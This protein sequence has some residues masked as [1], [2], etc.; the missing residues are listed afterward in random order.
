MS[1][2]TPNPNGIYPVVELNF[3]GVFL[4]NPF[5]YEPGMKFTFDD[6]DFS[7]MTY[8]ECITFLERFMQESIKKLYYYKP[9][10]PLLSGIAAIV[11]D[12][13]YASFIFDVYETDGIVSLYVDRDGQGIEDRFG[14]EIEEEED[15]DDSCIDGGE[16]D[17]EIE[18]LRD[19]EMDFNDDEVTMN[20]TEA[21][22]FL[23][24]LCGEEEEGNDNNIGDDVVGVK[25][26]QMLMGLGHKNILCAHTNPN[27]WI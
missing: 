16:N 13:G 10:K 7:G 27:A 3:K 5:S 25:R 17:D 15:G 8:Y 1:S 14:S 26:R 21:D 22:D 24:E 18:N 23:S 11:N 4:R 12:G 20:I 9:D 6:H 19:V 2:S